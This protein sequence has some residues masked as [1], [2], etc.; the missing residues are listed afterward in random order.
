MV[1]GFFVYLHIK[2][3]S[4]KDATVKIA[5]QAM[6]DGFDLHIHTCQ[7]LQQRHTK[8]IAISCGCHSARETRS[9]LYKINKQMVSGKA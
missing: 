1:T 9:T 5:V 2:Y 8:A 6:V 3:H 7:H 4:R